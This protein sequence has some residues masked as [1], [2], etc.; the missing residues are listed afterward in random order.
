MTE[1]ARMRFKSVSR[2]KEHGVMTLHDD[3]SFKLDPSPELR[4]EM[5]R[6]EEEALARSRVY[7]YGVGALLVGLGLTAAGLGWYL[8]R[9]FGKIAVNLSA[10]RPVD[11]VEIHRDSDGIVRLRMPGI[12][13]KLQTIQMAWHANEVVAEEADGFIEKLTEMQHPS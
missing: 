10:R 6:L 8:G 3:G 12:E 1:I 5:A 13:T 2:P 11:Q 7:G 9:V 4:D